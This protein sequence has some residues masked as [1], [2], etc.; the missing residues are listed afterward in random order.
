MILAIHVHCQNV[1]YVRKLYADLFSNYTKEV[2]PVYNHTKPLMVGV[3]FYLISINSFKEVEETISIT[4]SFNFNWTDPFLTW[5]PSLYG[6][7][8]WTVIDSSDMWVPF[9]VL[10]NNVNKMEPIGG[11]TKFNA[12]IIAHGDVIYSPGDVFEAKC[13]TDISKFPF[14]VHQCVFTFP[15]I[16]YVSRL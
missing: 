2:M 6:N 15:N 3:T 12:F 13:P 4:G 7:I 8:Y 16:S 14:D 5:N 10:T 11:D 9:M 1:S